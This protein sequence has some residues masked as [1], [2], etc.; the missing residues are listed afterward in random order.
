MRSGS[1][2]LLNT[3]LY[4][5]RDFI[6]YKDIYTSIIITLSLVIISKYSNSRPVV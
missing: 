2:I 6:R 5:L 4:L 3:Y 1:L